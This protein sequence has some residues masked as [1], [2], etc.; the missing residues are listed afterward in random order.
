MNK[1]CPYCLSPSDVE[2]KETNVGKVLVEHCP[3]CGFAVWLHLG[4]E[5][6]EERL[7][8]YE[9]ASK[10]WNIMGEIFGAEPKWTKKLKER[11]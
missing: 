5:K 3:T 1:K 10:I 8:A 2:F 11:N 7:K 4:S 9:A 6:Y